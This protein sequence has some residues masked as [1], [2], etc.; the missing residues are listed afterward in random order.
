MVVL[1]VLFAGEFGFEQVDRSQD[2]L[3]GLAEVEGV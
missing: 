3:F 1:S 2:A